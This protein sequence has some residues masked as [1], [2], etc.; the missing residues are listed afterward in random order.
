M[1]L[2]SPRLRGLPHSKRPQ[3]VTY[4][5][6]GTTRVGVDRV[7]VSA[8]ACVCMEAEEEWC[9]IC[10]ICSAYAAVTSASGRQYIP[11]PCGVISERNNFYFTVPPPPTNK[12]K[13][14]DVCSQREEGIHAHHA[15]QY[16]HTHQLWP[17]QR[18]KLKH[19]FKLC[20]WQQQKK[21]FQVRIL[22][23]LSRC[24]PTDEYITDDYDYHTTRIQSVNNDY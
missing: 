3:L 6:R 5:Y 16:T 15:R 1:S 2:P 19:Y 8:R 9:C 4:T 12:Y 22:G 10:R 24:S 17:F 21:K 13:P 20:L 14:N 18:T 7:R 23:I 11:T